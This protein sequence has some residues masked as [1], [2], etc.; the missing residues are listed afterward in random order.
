MAGRHIGNGRYHHPVFNY[1]EIVAQMPDLDIV[2][3]SPLLQ[4]PM[5]DLRRLYIDSSSHPSQIGYLLLNGMLCEGLG[6]RDAYRQA[7]ESVEHDLQALAQ[8]ILS[9]R[10]RKVVLTGRSVWLD[11]L[12]CYM[13][14]TGIARL[15]EAGLILAPL[16]PTPGQPGITALLPPGTIETCDLVVIS[17]GGQDLGPD[18]AKA[19]KTSPEV[20]NGATWIDWESATEQAIKDRH[21][22]PKF[23]RIVAG[24]KCRARVLRPV[25]KASMVE[26]GPAG[27]PS[28]TGLL[29]GFEMIQT[30]TSAGETVPT[31]DETTTTA[32]RIEGD[33]LLT[34]DNVAF[35]IGGNHSVLKFATGELQPSAASVAAFGDN[36]ASRAAI[37]ERLGVPYAHVIFPD[38]QSV[39]SDAFPLRPI[40][41]LGDAY[42][43]GLDPTLHRHVLYPADALKR[44]NETPFLALDTHMTSHGSLAVLAM[45]LKATGIPAQA[46]VER[47]R[48]CVSK[49][50][51]WSGDLGSKLTPRLYQEGLILEPDWPVT[52]L[53]SPG[54]F[55]DRLTDILISP[56]AAHDKTVL[57]FG[58]SFFRMMLKHLSAVFTRVI[59]LRTRFIHPEMVALIQPNI[60]FTGNAERY[61]SNVIQDREAQAFWLYPQMRDSSDLAMP[62]DF[63]EALSAITAPR[64]AS[65]RAFFARHGLPRAQ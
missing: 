32:Y 8:N 7:V 63:L 48:R 5:H 43:N 65:A 45:M 58:D 57:L 41:R 53:H 44:E 56:E 38:K 33:V 31:P 1:S 62:E 49:P 19:F 11:T 2:D 37:A 28:W 36:I 9:S 3:L 20:W 27:M 61:L 51:R 15:A 59:C 16:D 52:E 34:S 50:L 23:S 25:L 21:E 30:S 24:S 14:A 18:L 54:G 60:L 47:I 42:M 64:S 17:A 55:N 22:T 10:G 13:G 6:A 35:L 4:I 46:A 26:Q 40:H 29:A 39:L 12:M